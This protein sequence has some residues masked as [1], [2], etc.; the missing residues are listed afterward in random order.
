[1]GGLGGWLVGWVMPAAL[2]CVQRVKS[3][4]QLGLE[5]ERE[6]EFSY[7]PQ[8]LASKITGSIGTI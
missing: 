1:V 6:R 4:R 2:S 5:R 3:K 8:L 7:G